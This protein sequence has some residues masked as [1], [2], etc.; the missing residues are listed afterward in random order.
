MNSAE[1]VEFCIENIGNGEV[2]KWRG[3]QICHLRVVERGDDAL[4]IL[5]KFQR[6]RIITAV[7]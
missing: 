7:S 1:Q 2:S 5:Y 6:K 3:L 4:K